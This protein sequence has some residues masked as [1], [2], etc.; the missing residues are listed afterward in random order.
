MFFKVEAER[1]RETAS[2][3]AAQCKD[4][5]LEML[6]CVTSMKALIDVLS[7]DRLRQWVRSAG[8]AIRAANRDLIRFSIF[9]FWFHLFWFTFIYELENFDRCPI[10]FIKSDNEWDPLAFCIS[11]A[12]C[13]SIKFSIW[14]DSIVQFKL[15]F[16]LLDYS[17]ALNKLYLWAWMRS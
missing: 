14:F 12:N 10:N 17:F 13:K 15:I 11:V 16:I 3:E 1:P 2:D 6:L 7:I 5:R 9:D 4:Y 8:F